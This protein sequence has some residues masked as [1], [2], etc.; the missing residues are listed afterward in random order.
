MSDVAYFVSGVSDHTPM[1]DYDYYAYG[2][3]NISF[4]E[5]LRVC[6]FLTLSW[7]SSFNLRNAPSQE[8]FYNSVSNKPENSLYVA[9]GPDDLRLNV[10]YD[11]SRQQSFVYMTMDLDAKGAVVEYDKI[12]VKNPEN[13]GNKKNEILYV[14]NKNV[15][16]ENVS[17]NPSETTVQ[18][19]TEPEKAEVIDI[20][21]DERL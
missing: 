11:F 20:I 17:K 7:L 5:S 12:I 15:N 21:K 6:R 3:S 19:N 18:K 4:R 10:G 13:F 16:A 2:S 14:N 9:I 1:P 8:Q